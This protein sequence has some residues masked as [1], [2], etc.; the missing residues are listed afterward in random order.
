MVR[1]AAVKS[2][3]LQRAVMVPAVL[4]TKLAEQGTAPAFKHPTLIDR[5]W[6]V[7]G[8]MVSWTPGSTSVSRGNL[9]HITAFFFPSAALFVE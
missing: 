9:G 7:A 1:R 8:R 4:G 6:P 5:S 2:A 3:V